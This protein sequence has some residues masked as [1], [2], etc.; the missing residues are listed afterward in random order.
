[1]RQ[2]PVGEYRFAGRLEQ[3]ALRAEHD[4]EVEGA[5]SH[6]KLRPHVGCSGSLHPSAGTTRPAAFRFFAS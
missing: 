3:H 4:R 6:G 2:A 5:L 1:M